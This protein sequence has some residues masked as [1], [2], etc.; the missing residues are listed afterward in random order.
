MAFLF[1]RN[2]Q[3]NSMELARSTRELMQRLALEEKPN[4][5]VGSTP[6]SPPLD[7]IPDETL[8]LRKS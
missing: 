1:S 5:K 7:K 4:P 8:R 3:K 2:R 6:T